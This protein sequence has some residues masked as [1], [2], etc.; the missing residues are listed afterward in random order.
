MLCSAA[1][2]G[3]VNVPPYV[4]LS[5]LEAW[6]A[7]TGN[8]IDSSGHGNNGHIDDFKHTKTTSGTI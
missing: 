6:W 3:Q 2:F 5:N 7:F 8:A 4:P 1:A